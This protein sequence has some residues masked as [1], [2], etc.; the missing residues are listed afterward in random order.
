MTTFNHTNGV[1]PL[2]G[3][4]SLPKFHLHKHQK[5][6]FVAFGQN[7]SRLSM[8]EMTNLESV[9]KSMKEAT[10]KRKDG[11][12][13]EQSAVPKETRGSPYDDIQR[14]SIMNESQ[15]E[16]FSMSGVSNPIFRTENRARSNLGAE[17]SQQSLNTMS[18]LKKYGHQ[19]QRTLWDGVMHQ[20]YLQDLQQETE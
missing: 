13:I 4:G 19:R 16:Y 3:F 17:A 20:K 10:A 8:Q 14:K 18:S 12:G 7:G 5:G 15:S 1:S 11:N 9:R 6:G 2:Q